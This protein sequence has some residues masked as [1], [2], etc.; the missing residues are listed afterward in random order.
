[1]SSGPQPD[2]GNWVPQEKDVTK[3]RRESETL[4]SSLQWETSTSARQ[5]LPSSRVTLEGP[6]PLLPS[7]WLFQERGRWRRGRGSE[8][9]RESARMS[10]LYLS[11]STALRGQAL[12]RCLLP[13]SVSLINA[14]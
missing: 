14:S 8:Q 5:V 6:G 13:A 12:S 7:C 1:M 4:P 2:E 9:P 10:G 11:L 3:A